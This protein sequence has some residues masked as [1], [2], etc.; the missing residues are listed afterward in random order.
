M[1]ASPTEKALHARFEGHAPFAGMSIHVHD[2]AVRFGSVP[3]TAL[4]DF[5]RLLRGF[6]VASEPK[7]R[8]AAS[9]KRARARTQR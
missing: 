8:E 5:V 1:H 2:G 9:P 3:L 4:D 7:Q 6:Q